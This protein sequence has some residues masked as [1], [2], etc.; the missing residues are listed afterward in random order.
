ML[1]FS[2]SM[3]EDEGPA[4]TR[5]GPPGEQLPVHPG[6]R[7]APRLSPE[8][9]YIFQGGPLLAQAGSLGDSPESSSCSLSPPTLKELQPLWQ[10]LHAEDSLG[11]FL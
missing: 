5:S 9:G 1:N 6:S 7:A 2:S 11:Y 8:F 3:M 10:N 4:S